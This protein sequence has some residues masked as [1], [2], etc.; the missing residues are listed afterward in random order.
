LEHE[1]DHGV[2]WQTNTAEHDKN[3]NPNKRPDSYFK[4][5]EEKRVITGSEY[6]TGVANGE[7]KPIPKGRERYNSSY[8]SHKEGA[9]TFVP[10]NSP[11]SNKKIAK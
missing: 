1:F 10:V 7:L 9:N 8:R 2:D 5:K 3:N 11:I 4:N 6:K